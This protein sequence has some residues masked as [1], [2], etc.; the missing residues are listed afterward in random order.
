MKEYE[1]AEIKP[2]LTFDVAEKNAHVRKVL[3]MS[4]GS[5]IFSILCTLFMYWLYANEWNL[6]GKI[7]MVALIMSLAIP[8]SGMIRSYKYAKR[9]KEV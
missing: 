3:M 4:G 5:F 2:R 9:M 6:F 8:I 1:G 7:I